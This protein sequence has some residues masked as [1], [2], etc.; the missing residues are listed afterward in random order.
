M[1]RGE[2]EVFL[3]TQITEPCEGMYTV[4]AA[5]PMLFFLFEKSCFQ[6]PNFQVG[7]TQSNLFDLVIYTT[8]AT[9]QASGIYRCNLAQ[10]VLA[11]A[12][13]K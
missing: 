7:N 2:M 5:L 1:K 4:I 6:D 10:Q 9:L 13:L 8:R 11:S 3:S 12:F